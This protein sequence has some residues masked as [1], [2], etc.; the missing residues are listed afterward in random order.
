MTAIAIILAI[1]PFTILNGQAANIKREISKIIKY[2]TDID[3]EQ[4]PGFLLAILDQDTS[5]VFDFGYEEGCEDQD[6]T[7]EVG[8]ITKAFTGTLISLLEEERSINL[9]MIVNDIL[10]KEYQNHHLSQLTVKDLLYHQSPFPKIPNNLGKNQE[11]TGNPYGHY[12]KSNL[13]EFYRDYLPS[14]SSPIYS[15]V[16]YA[17]LELIIEQLTGLTYEENIQSRIC[18]PLGLSHTF[19]TFTEENK[20]RQS[21][22][23][24]R[25][26]DP[27]L[28]RDYASFGGSEGLKSNMAD[29]ITF[30]TANL[31]TDHQESL[32]PSKIHQK[33]DV[34]SWDEDTYYSRGWVILDY[35]SHDIS[36][37]SGRT[38][39]Q[40]S[41]IAMIKE[42]KKAVIILSKSAI[43]TEDLGMLVLRMINNN[44]KK[45]KS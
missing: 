36:I 17:L 25:S 13:M 12:S 37:Q 39:G 45:S 20:L 2:D 6:S 15:H 23:Y 27:A 18:K 31:N 29:L 10:P 26:L 1:L 4:H 24:S 43:G 7:F 22:G 42:N 21:S 8:S 40:A 5:F 14:T 28:P 9:E 34:S 30:V 32:I 44:W 41:F 16:N 3:L 35:K 38:T 11:S 19:S 33:Q